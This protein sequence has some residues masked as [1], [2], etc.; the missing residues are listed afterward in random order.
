MD[1]WMVCWLGGSKQ[2]RK[3]KKWRG[4]VERRQDMPWTCKFACTH[5]LSLSLSLKKKQYIYQEMKA[6]LLVGEISSQLEKRLCD[7]A[8][9]TQLRRARSVHIDYGQWIARNLS[10]SLS[11]LAANHNP[12]GGRRHNSSATD[13]TYYSTVHVYG[14]V[15][16]D[17]QKKTRD[18]TFNSFYYCSF[19]DGAFVF[20]PFS[21]NSI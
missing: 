7:P 5:S 3:Q 8:T 6:A 15:I 13:S 4:I 9:A 18:A 14:M 1:G 2:P 19:L 10:L 11:P 16:L 21:N 20:I 17:E 12:T